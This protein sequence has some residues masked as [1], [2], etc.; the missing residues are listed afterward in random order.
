[1][2]RSLRTPTLFLAAGTAAGALVAG[3]LAGNGNGST[4]ETQP[5]LVASPEEA[6]IELVLRQPFR[7]D[8]PGRHTMR[9][10]APAYT[11]GHLLVLR[12]EPERWRLRQSYDNVL[13]VG[14]ETARR[15]NHG[16][17]SG[18][19]VVLVPGALEADAPLFLGA[20]EL[21][22][23]VTAA[24]AAR[25]A[26]DARRAGVAA[27]DDFP[28]ARTLETAHLADEADLFTYAAD[29]VERYAP[30]EVDLIESLRVPRLR[31]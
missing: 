28:D 8:R 13:Y 17:G 14:A 9:A 10:E 7:L 1:M 22:E 19:L 27:V 11:E 25:Q 6:P 30:D 24:E 21:P 31:R 4:Q 3:A 12:A 18:H 16:V 15:V 23:R 20:P 29:L 5:A 2:Q 26:A